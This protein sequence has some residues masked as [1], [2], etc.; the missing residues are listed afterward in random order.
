M[1]NEIKRCSWGNISDQYQKYHDNE[2]GEPVYNDRQLFE[3]LCLESFQSG[4]SWRIILTKREN[5][6]L[7]FDNFDYDLMSGYTEKDILRLLKNEGIVRNRRKIEAVI[8]NAKRMQEIVEIEG[9][10]AHFV[11]RFQK[12]TNEDPIKLIATT[13]ESIALAAEFKDRG[14]KF[15]GPTTVYAFMQAMGIV[16]DHFE[17]CYRREELIKQNTYHRFY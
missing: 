8:N 1:S 10:L 15:L 9:S 16:N 3:K 11:W 4:L 5:F 17:N 2:W 7:A 12:P 6:R 14:W 13:P